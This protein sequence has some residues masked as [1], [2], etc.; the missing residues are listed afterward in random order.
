MPLFNYQ[1][2][3]NYA[4]LITY[5]PKFYYDVLEMQ[6][7]LQAE[8]AALDTFMENTERV[9]NDCFIDSMDEYTVS[10]TED[11][12]NIHLYKQRTLEERKR[13][14]KTF[15]VGHGRLSADLIRQT[16]MAYTGADVEVYL[17]PINRTPGATEYE[18]GDN[19]LYINFLRGEQEIFFISDVDTLL[20][21]LI[22]AHLDWQ[23]ALTYRFA[24]CT[25]PK[26]KKYKKDFTPCGTVPDVATL[27]LTPGSDI[28]VD[29]S[30]GLEGR[31][32]YRVSFTPC[33]TSV[34]RA[35]A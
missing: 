32:N 27:G 8:G 7:I 2:N 22:P 13:L 30:S 26:R 10:L 34:C 11:F 14:I 29:A 17:L 21:R 5:Y 28:V 25:S 33:G 15:F 31:K 16:I 1:W 9:F 12:L 24:V 19:R 6:A 4:E 18:A 3:N 20:T 23:S 35:G